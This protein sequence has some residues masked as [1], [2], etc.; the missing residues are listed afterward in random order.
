MRF[1]FFVS[2]WDGCA[3][4]ATMYNN[5]R[6]AGFTIPPGKCYLADAGF[7]ICDAL[8][9]PYRAV[10]YHLAEWARW[11]QRYIIFTVIFL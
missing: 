11:A 1:L 5:A 4:D 9:M 8:L 6:L 7:G 3:A 10:R 2:G